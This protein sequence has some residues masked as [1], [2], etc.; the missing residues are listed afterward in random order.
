MSSSITTSIPAGVIGGDWCIQNLEDVQHE[1]NQCADTAKH[2]VPSDFNTICCAGD[3]I[4]TTQDLWDYRTRNETEVDTANLVCCLYAKI[5]L[6]SSPSTSITNGR[7][8]CSQGSPT[9]LASL[10]ATNT[11]N[12][13][14]YLRTYTSA[15]AYSWTGTTGVYEDYVPTATPRCLWVYT[16]TGVPMNEVTVPTAM[17]ST[18]SGGSTTSSS[19]PSSETSSLS[20]SVTPSMASGSTSFVRETITT[21]SG[22]LTLTLPASLGGGRGDRT[23]TQATAL[24]TTTNGAGGQTDATAMPMLLLAGLA[25]GL[26]KT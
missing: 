15:G 2:Q 14:L 17:I 9:P 16:K 22:T 21:T 12:A 20:M 5:P 25:I 18:M 6:D 23:A 13:A 7:H 11:E 26:L 10:A 1:P 3:I 19:M 4:D 24:T 8:T